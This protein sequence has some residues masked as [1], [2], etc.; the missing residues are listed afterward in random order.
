MALPDPEE[1]R[2]KAYSLRR[3]VMDYGMGLVIGCFGIFFAFAHKLGYQ[4]DLEP[5]FRY[6]LS[7]L[8]IIY[9]AFRIYRGYQ[10]KYYTE[11]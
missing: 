4:F 9:G 10:K 11:E 3:S 7:G 1:R 6:S 8:F 5:L 2:R